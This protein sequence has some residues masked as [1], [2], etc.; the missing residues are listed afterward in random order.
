[1]TSNSIKYIIALGTTAT[2][3]RRQTKLVSINSEQTLSLDQYRDLVDV[4]PELGWLADIANE[5]TRRAYKVDVAEFIAFTNLKDH[6]A[7]R[8][9]ARAHL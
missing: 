5:K 6:S 8:T 3:R 4:P 9:V 1:L 7:L 2:D